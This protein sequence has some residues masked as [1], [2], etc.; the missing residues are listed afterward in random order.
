MP[1]PLTLLLSTIAI[2]TTYFTMPLWPFRKSNY[3]PRGK[4]C[5]ITGGSSGLGKALAERLVE[6]GAHVTIVGRDTKKAEG[7]VE[8]LKVSLEDKQENSS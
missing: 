5:Y 2:I 3:D 7:V 6:Q 1:T 8:K 4:H